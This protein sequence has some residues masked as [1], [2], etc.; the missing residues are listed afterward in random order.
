[1]CGT[2]EYIKVEWILDELE[3]KAPSHKKER[4]LIRIR[5]LK[6][7]IKEIKCVP[8]MPISDE[9]TEIESVS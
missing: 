1:M 3:L 2:E 8:R 9:Q 7:N 6:D 4:I 5:K